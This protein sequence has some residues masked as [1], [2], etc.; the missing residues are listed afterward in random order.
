MEKT[1]EVI[2]ISDLHLGSS[3]C[4]AKTIASFLQKINNKEILT[5]KLVLNGDIFDSQDFRRL[6]KDHWKILS[7]IRK[8]SDQ[9]E[10]FW[11]I[12]NHDGDKC[13]FLSHLLGVNF[14]EY[15]I[16]E[17]G[18]KRIYITHGHFFDEIIIKHKNLIGFFDFAYRWIQY[19]DRSSKT[20]HWLKK[21]SKTYLRAN[22]VIMEKA[23]IKAKSLNCDIAICGHT[24]LVC[25][26]EN[27]FNSGC[28]TELPCHYLEICEG[29]I[30]TVDYE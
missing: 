25:S 22:N 26:K 23:V 17:S 13:E 4:Q 2:V 1:P 30:T 11:I 24:H 29:N 27:Y 18:D 3:V 16:L 14:L 5:N 9:V 15:L 28:W 21:Q 8:L 10:I 19:L 6:K 20:A 12:G 7:L